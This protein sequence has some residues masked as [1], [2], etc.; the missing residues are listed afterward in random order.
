MPTAEEAGQMWDSDDHLPNENQKAQLLANEWNAETRFDITGGEGLFNVPTEKVEREDGRR[1][2]SATRKEVGNA[3][4]RHFYRVPI[5]ILTEA[6]VS[7]KDGSTTEANVFK[8]KTWEVLTQLGLKDLVVDRIIFFPNGDRTYLQPYARML[9]IECK[10]TEEFEL[11]DVRDFIHDGRSYRILRNKDVENIL[12]WFRNLVESNDQPI[13]WESLDRFEWQSS[14]KAIVQPNNHHR[15][16]ENADGES[17]STGKLARAP[18]TKREIPSQTKRREARAAREVAAEVA[19]TIGATRGGDPSDPNAPPPVQDAQG[20]SPTAPSQRA[21][22]RPVARKPL[23][24][25]AWGQDAPTPPAGTDPNAPPPFYL[26]EP[27]FPMCPRRQQPMQPILI[28]GHG[29]H[30]K[31]VARRTWD[32]RGQSY[33]LW[34]DVEPD[35]PVRP[36]MPNASSLAANI[37]RKIPGRSSACP[38]EC[39]AAGHVS[40]TNI[41]RAT[42][43]SEM[44]PTTR[45]SPETQ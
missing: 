19:E 30:L 4:E 36:E 8:A 7:V 3:N 22:P 11:S 44:E 10:P 28:S 15:S 32:A 2:P 20:A 33:T 39:L 29:Q 38:T 18:H 40:S 21:P 43:A 37:K 14:A 41:S 45:S 42:N 1:P 27:Y 23:I 24:P 6:T 35:Q 34:L 16:I 12:T 31:N 5:G 9:A 13:Q 17:E 26:R 25:E